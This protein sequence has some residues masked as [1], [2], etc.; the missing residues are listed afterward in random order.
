[1]EVSCLGD[2]QGKGRSRSDAQQQPRCVL[3]INQSKPWVGAIF[4]ELNFESHLIPM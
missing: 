2:A 4:S 3:E 1:V